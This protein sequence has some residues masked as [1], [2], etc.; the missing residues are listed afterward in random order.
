MDVVFR[1]SIDAYVGAPIAVPKLSPEQITP[2]MVDEYHTKY[3]QALV[4]LFDAH[5]AK[6][7]NANASIVFVDHTMV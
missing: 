4:N 5:K 2:Q 1:H 3:T 6:H 7:G